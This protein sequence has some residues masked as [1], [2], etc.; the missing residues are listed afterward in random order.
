MLITADD[1]PVSFTMDGSP[2]ERVEPV[3]LTL[4]KQHLHMGSVTS[5]DD[6]IADWIAAARSY[7]EEQT[8]RQCVDAVWEYALDGVPVGCVI[9]LPR[10]PL[11]E[12]ESIVY[13][14][15]DGEEQTFAAENYRVLP[16][17]IQPESG[18]PAIDPYCAPGRIELVSGAAWP[19]VRAGARSLRIRRTCGYGAT[20]A[21]MPSVMRAV[22]YQIVSH[23]ESHRDAVSD[24]EMY[25]L[26]MGAEAQLKAFKWTALPVIP[27][28][29]TY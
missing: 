29:S 12:V 6:L 25:P 2:L 21:A 24:I 11:A 9:E 19:T 3:T 14:D 18:N 28:Q 8:G 17:F 16:S 4:V 26:P 15:A 22:L 10:P 23:L 5:Q 7:F 27:P 13:D 20:A 1:R